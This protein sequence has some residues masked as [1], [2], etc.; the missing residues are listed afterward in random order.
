[1]HLKIWKAHAATGKRRSKQ[2]KNINTNMA[3]EDLFKKIVAHAKEYGFVFPS[4]E[5]Y[6]G[7]SAVYDYGQNGVELKNNIKRYWWDAMTQLNENIV[8]L[9]SA[10]FMHPTI[11]KASGHVDAFND[12]LI[13]NRDSKK[14]YRADVL[15]E[16]EIAK[17]DDKINKEVAKA[18]KKFGDSFDEK[19]YRETNPRVQEHLAKRN[20]LHERYA[21]AMNDMNLEEL[22]QIILDYEIVCPISGTKNWTEV[23]QFNLMFSTEM[24]STSEGSMKVYLRPETAQ[25]IFVNFLNVQK[26]GRM[27]IPFGIAQIGKAFRNEIVARQFIFRMREFEQM[28][29]QFFVRPGEEL[30]WFA[31]WKETRLKWHKALGLGDEKYRYHDHEKLAHYANAATDIEFLM[32]F[33]F[34]EVEGIHSRTNF[35]LGNHEK[36][37]GKKI[38]YFDPEL[39]QSYTPYVIE[40][41][42]GV[43]RMFLSV[44]ASSY[45]EEQLENGETRVVLHLPA[46]LAPVKAAIMPLV[47]K[48]GLPEKAQELI[49]AL[50]FDFKVQYDEKDSI[51]KRYR[52]QDAIGTP[53]CITVDHQTLEDGTV[54]IRHRDSM[55]QERI[56]ASEVASV[57]NKEVSMKELLKK[58]V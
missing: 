46:P 34:K 15:I 17:Y 35:D 21:K 40:T 45:E 55:R 1:M 25:G 9:D 49:D 39:N 5:I 2:N 33:G 57:L 51:G 24:G 11:W 48:D 38:Q 31:K 29:M 7:L 56:P 44:F 6:D 50:K 54:T 58:L 14:R 19:L 13:D 47:R 52:R 8:G 23:R 3:Q 18:A 12:P 30:K 41:S 4:S 53:F 16:D 36:F 26:T 43:D 20:E 37:S 10:I 28:E 32:P 42:I 22:R 27:R